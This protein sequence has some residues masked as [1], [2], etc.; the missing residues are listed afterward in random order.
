MRGRSGLEVVAL[1]S[2]AGWVV[3]SCSSGD[4]AVRPRIEVSADE[5]MV[6]ESVA[7]TISGVEPHAMVEVG[8]TLSR[9]DG[10]WSSSATFEADEHGRVRV[11]DS[12]PATGDYEGVDPMGLFWAARPLAAGDASDDANEEQITLTAT[13]A[14][15]EVASTSMRRFHLRPGAVKRDVREQ[16]LVATL[17][18]PE[19][20]GPHPGVLVLGGSEGGMTY[21]S[22]KASELASHGYTTMALAYFDPAATDGL[23]TALASIPLEYIDTALAWL[24]E[25]PSVDP[26]RVGLVGSSRGAELALLVAAGNPSVYAVV[27]YAPTNV[28][29]PAVPPATGSAWTRGGQPVPTM[30][31]SVSG[32]ITSSM[33]RFNAA[34][35]DSVAVAQAAIPVESINGG[36]LLLSGEDDELWP[37]SR[38]ADAVVQRLEQN[39]FAHPVDHLRY[40]GAGH[41]IPTPY[42]PTTDLAALGA[43][44]LGGR[45]EPTAKA[46]ED[47]WP[48]VLDFLAENLQN[49]S[50]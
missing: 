15:K 11:A 8:L 47:Q 20:A 19:T 1:V 48:K 49:P 7:I 36:V 17:F 45:P 12:A 31:S 16:G 43:L 24:A 5:V 13:V 40:P 38:M 18:V 46:A 9:S 41:L 42:Q 25:Q 4:G 29:W 6:D 28:A 14:D 34:L 3:G 39:G 22:L 50:D 23:P 37:S 44:R 27:A 32:S 21:S 30:P 10:T 35:D 2:L 26:S 33:D